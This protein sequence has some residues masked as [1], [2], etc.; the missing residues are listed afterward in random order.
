[1][2]DESLLRAHVAARAVLA[3]TSTDQLDLPTPCDKWSVSQL[4]DHLVG[5]QNW[6]YAGLVG[7]EM[8]PSDGVSAG[9]Y[10]AAFDEAAGRM[11]AATDDG[12]VMG[13]TVNAG[14]GEM[15]APALVGMIT[16]DT[17]THAWDLAVATGQDRDLDPALA[18]Q[19]LAQAQESIPESFRDPEGNIFGLAQP[20]PDGACAADRLAAFL[21]RT[22]PA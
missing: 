15:P 6:G 21:G 8:E 3:A 19:L 5:A 1:M 9:D 16:S 20:A 4:I 10:L 2:A 12:E 22:V 13:G 7:A 14:F 18:E 17:L 11:A